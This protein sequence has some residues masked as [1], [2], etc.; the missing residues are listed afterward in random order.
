MSASRDF[1]N[2]SSMFPSEE[3]PPPR[4]LLHGASSERDAPSQSP[5]HPS[6]KVPVRRALLHVPQ[7]GP[8]WR[9]M[10]VSRASSAYPSGSP[11]R[12]PSLQVPFTELPQRETLHLQ[13]SFQ[14][15]LKIPGRW[16]HYSLPN[17]ASFH[18]QRLPFLTFR[19]PRKGAPLQVPLTEL[20]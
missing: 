3:A 14:P 13:R 17:S 19:A 5:I 8:L 9:E 12:E 16:A 4:G 6:L 20:P 11:A 18:S 7:T 10:P 1:P 2:I 15:Y